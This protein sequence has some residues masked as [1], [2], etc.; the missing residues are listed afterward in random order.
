MNYGFVATVPLANWA[1][2]GV[3][4]GTAAPTISVICVLLVELVLET[5]TFPEGSIAHPR[6]LV[7]KL[8]A[9]WNPPF[10]VVVVP[11][12]GV[13]LVGERATPVL[14][15]SETPKSPEL[16]AVLF[17][18]HTLPAPSTATTRPVD[19]PPANIAVAVPGV[20]VTVLAAPGV[21]LP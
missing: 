5:H 2:I 17:A 6:R 10:S 16:A 11:V 7:K 1:E 15:N 14:V 8:A 12:P 9:F 21:E 13:V 3:T 20:N 4:T 19:T 18:I